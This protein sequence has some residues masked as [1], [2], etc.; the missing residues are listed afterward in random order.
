MGFWGRGGCSVLEG[1]LGFAGVVLFLLVSSF[2]GSVS[3]G[4]AFCLSPWVL[5][6]FGE[7]WV[8]WVCGVVWFTAPP[9]FG[10]GR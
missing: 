4:R 5:L 3:S 2:S 7:G 8:A 1:V 6:V 9:F 10:G